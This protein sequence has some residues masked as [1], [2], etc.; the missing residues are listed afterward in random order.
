M[1]GARIAKAFNTL[2][3]KILGFDPQD[4]GGRRVILFR[5][6]VFLINTGRRRRFAVV[7]FG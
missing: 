1:P 2:Y 3:F 7:D 4:V 5:T 6:M